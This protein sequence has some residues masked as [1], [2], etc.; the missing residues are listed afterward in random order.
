MPAIGLGTYSN[1]ET[2]RWP[3]RADLSDL[4]QDGCDSMPPRL[5]LIKTGG[6]HHEGLTSIQL[7]FENGIKSPLFDAMNI[8]VEED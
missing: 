6:T 4:L 1:D 7:I 8:T 5:E 2:F 3:S